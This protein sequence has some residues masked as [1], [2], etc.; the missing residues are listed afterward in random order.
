M[1]LYRATD[2][3]MIEALGLLDS[4][5]DSRRAALVE[6]PDRL[7]EEPWPDGLTVIQVILGFQGGQGDLRTISSS[8]RT[9]R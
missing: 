8:S 9:A 1:D 5:H 6:W 2:L 7:G 3:A 4:L